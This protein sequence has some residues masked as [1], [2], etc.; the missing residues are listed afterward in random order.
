MVNFTLYNNLLWL[1]F[2]L[3]LISL[4]FFVGRDENEWV[5]GII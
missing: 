4:F 3:I 5:G 2:D 1:I